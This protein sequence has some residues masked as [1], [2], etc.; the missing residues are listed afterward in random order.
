MNRMPEIGERVRYTAAIAKHQCSG[1]VVRQYPARTWLDN[2]DDEVVR[3]SE[4]CASV[5]VDAPLPAWWPYPDTD[6]FAPQISE[7][8]ALEDAQAAIERGNQ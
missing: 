3:V 4:A 6:R 1:I 5:K 8:E 2:D 7:L